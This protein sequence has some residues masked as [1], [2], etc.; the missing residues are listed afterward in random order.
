MAAFPHSMVLYSMTLLFIYLPI[1]L[2]LRLVL[3]KKIN[4]NS[5]FISV[6]FWRILGV[7]VAGGVLYALSLWLYFKVL[8]K[9]KKEF[10]FSR[11]FCF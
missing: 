1:G 11:R 5:A 3:F 9:I 8:S 7:Y 10:R 2:G 4:D 6:L